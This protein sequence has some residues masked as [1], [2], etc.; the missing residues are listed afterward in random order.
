MRE[1]IF[2]TYNPGKLDDARKISHVLKLNL[3]I[4]GIGELGLE[5]VEVDES[6][7]SFEANARIKYDTLRPH[8]DPKLI[9]VTDDSGL[10]IDALNG[11]P[12]IHS[13]R[14]N[15]ERRE[16]SDEELVAK[17]RQELAGK[18]NRGARFVA[19]AAIGG[20]NV[21]LQ[22]RRAE[23]MGEMLEEPDMQGA[24]PGYPFRAFFYVAEIGRMLYQV[25]DIPV[26]ER[27]GLK[28]HREMLWESIARAINS[29]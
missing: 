25:H 14:W 29:K 6:G 9:L 12:G 4:T 2:G 7:E 24:K 13:R 15:D 17:M 23:L 16:M 27:K 8:I 11:E 18:Q 3:R 5:R 10:A 26:N 19:V 21:P 20:A 22:L 28:T 1:I